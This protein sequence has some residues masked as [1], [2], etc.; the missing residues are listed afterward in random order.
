MEETGNLPVVVGWNGDGTN[1]PLGEEMGSEEIELF[2][3]GRLIS[4]KPF[5][6]VGIRVAIYRSWHFVNNLKMEEVDGNRFIFSFPFLVCRNRVL[7]QSR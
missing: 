5:N 2:L 7:E 4:D 6:R 1:D 3:V